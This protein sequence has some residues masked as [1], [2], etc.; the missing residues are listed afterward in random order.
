MGST[1]PIVCTDAPPPTCFLK[2]PPS[3]SPRILPSPFLSVLRVSVLP[4]PGPSLLPALPG[5][6]PH[7]PALRWPVRPEPGAPRKGGGAAGDQPKDPSYGD[8]FPEQ[9]APERLRSPIGSCLEGETFASPS[10]FTFTAAHIGAPDTRTRTLALPG[11]VRGRGSCSGQVQTDE[12]LSIFFV[13]VF[14]LK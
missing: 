1:V 13:F 12:E 9:R 11:A 6:Q 7:V 10:P 4:S 5:P 3:S 2:F 14:S 8:P